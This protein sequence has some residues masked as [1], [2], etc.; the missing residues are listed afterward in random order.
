MFI[1]GRWKTSYI[2]HP[3]VAE[4]QVVGIPD[5]RLGEV[6]LAWIRLKTGQNATEDEI[7]QFCEARSRTSKIPQHCRFVDEFPTT[8]HREDSRSFKIREIE[9]RERGLQHIAT[10]ETA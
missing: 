8:V 9:T 10:R 4:V 3:K 2:T 6:V 7:R 5:E 1:R